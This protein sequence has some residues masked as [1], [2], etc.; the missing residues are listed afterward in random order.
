MYVALVD[1]CQDGGSPQQEEW[2]GLILCRLTTRSLC[3]CK[4]V[5]RSWNHSSWTSSTVRSCPILLPDSSIA[6]RKENATSPAPLVNIPPCSSYPSPSRMSLSHIAAA[7][8]SSA[9]VLGVATLSAIR[10]L[11]ND[12]Y[13]RITSVLV[14][15]LTWVRSDSLLTLPYVW[16][17]EDEGGWVHRC[18][19]LLI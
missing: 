7:A 18:E 3:S 5:C 16:I 1:P 12:C 15:R 2:S 10:W 19:H 13:C 8:S 9:G 4:C 6:P 14:A 17:W 11:T